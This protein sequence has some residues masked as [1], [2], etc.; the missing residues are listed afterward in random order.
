MIRRRELLGL[1]LAATPIASTFRTALAQAAALDE[2]SAFDFAALKGRA[3]ALA[4]APYR[5]PSTE[6]PP[7]LAQLGYD[8]FQSI[9]YRPSEGLWAGDKLEFQLQ[10]FH[11]GYKFAKRVQMFE[12][13]QG[14]AREIAYDPRMFDF[15]KSGLDGRALGADL[16]FAGFRIHF[17]T[18][19]DADVAAFLGA[20]YFRAVG[21]DSRQY[22]ASARGLAIGTGSDHAEEFPDFTAFWFER[23]QAGSG[24]LTLY[25]S[26]DSPSI[27][28][29][30]R[31][32]LY[33][34]APLVMD[35]DAA[36]YPRTAIQRLGVAPLTS[37]YLCG[38]ND[39][40]MG[41][42]WRPEIH[43]SDGLSM[44]RGTGERIWRPLTNPPGVHLYSYV[45]RDPRGFG[46]L[47][48]DRT[49]DHY[50]DDGARYELRPS[51]W[52]AT[53]APAGTSWGEGSVALL[54]YAAREETIDNVAAMWVPA[55]A[56]S[57]GDEL[58]F[59]YQLRWGLE[60]DSPISLARVVATRT[61]IGGVVG[62][63]RT[64]FSWR[65]AI[66]FVGG[67][68]PT[69]GKDVVIEPVIAAS[70]GSVELVS[71]RPQFDI[72][73][74]RTM[75]DLALADDSVEPIDLRMYL[76]VGSEPLTETWMYQWIPP[77][78]A[79]RDRLWRVSAFHSLNAGS[80]M[81]WS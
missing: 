44:Q 9:R 39:R 35:I 68:L 33:P 53:R 67:E 38:E 40:R 63:P 12:V 43:D 46:L 78:P 30:Y 65:F 25:A 28:G 45:D 54:E 1:A 52:V 17:H 73:G 58:L 79:E 41:D 59:S 4:Q 32:D 61:G 75:F 26:L 18:N 72:K 34:G 37:M 66:D 20:S 24:R 11:R 7:A 69:I 8:A 62:Q 47:Q 64:H 57:A 42:D 10:F 48:R 3:R 21:S 74:C 22:G 27:A 6:M 13:T 5:P 19:W 15:G 23:P 71:A 76:R 2:P 56:P 81:P 77:P 50:Q 49:F 70:R 36:L 31:F 80:S 16:G 29:A 14:Q 55:R 51:V 60:V